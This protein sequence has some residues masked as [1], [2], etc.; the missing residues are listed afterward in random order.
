MT[1]GG[2]AIA[3]QHM[4]STETATQIAQRQAPIREA[5]ERSEIAHRFDL[6]ERLWILCECAAP[7][8]RGIR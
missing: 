8:D 6:G 4:L 7:D 1:G 3:S 2:L 5:N